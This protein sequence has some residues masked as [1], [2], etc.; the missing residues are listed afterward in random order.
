M[1]QIPYPV[2]MT[3]ISA[4]WI[5]VRG[6]VCL[7]NRRFR[8]KREVQLL[9]VYICLVVVARF[10]FFPF[11]KVDGKVQ[12]L[13]FD[14]ARMIP[15]RI[16][17]API[18]HLLEYPDRREALLN[19]IGNTAMFVPLG[20]VWPSVYRELDTHWKVIAAGVGF[21]L[22]I[23]ILQLPFF[24]RV[25][26]ID[27]LILNSLGFLLGYGLYLLGKQLK[28]LIVMSVKRHRGLRAY[29]EE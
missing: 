8:W 13:L 17:L 29:R 22:C 24:D 6:I 27:D 2:T 20:I 12:P 11:G 25:T 26:D 15:P 5:L 23:E 3:A 4:L 1:I 18:V 19:L 10:T 9:L 21:S 28:R 16:N 7:K 14:L